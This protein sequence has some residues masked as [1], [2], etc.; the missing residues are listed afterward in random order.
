LLKIYLDAC[1][2]NRLTDDQ[3]QSRIHTEAEAVE[4]VLH[5]VRKGE[6]EWKASW[7]DDKYVYELTSQ[8]AKHSDLSNCA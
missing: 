6:A 8:A 5:L 2:L 3:S 7:R 4:R 1:A